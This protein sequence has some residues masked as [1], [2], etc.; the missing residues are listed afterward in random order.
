MQLP[1]YALVAYDAAELTDDEPAY[2]EVWALCADA[3]DLF[4]N[5]RP[6]AR[7]RYELLGCAVEGAL[8][9]A[10]DQARSEGSAPLGTLVLEALDKNGHRVGEWYLEDV[11]LLGDRLCA[12]DLSLRDLTVEASEPPDA[13]QADYP[14]RP[15]LSPGYL[16]LGAE[17]QP[18]GRCKDLARVADDSST[19]EEPPIRLTGCSPRG[20]LREALD[21]GEEDLGHARLLR[22][23]AFGW[24]LTSAVEGEITAWIPSARGRGLVDLTLEPW[25]D[26]PPFAAR[27][28]WD[29]WWDGRPARTNLWA[30]CSAEGRD[31][32]LTTALENRHRR[33]PH[34]RT[35]YRPPGPTYHLDG[36]H[37]TDEKGFYCAIGE[38][39]NGPGG[40]FGGNWG[41]LTDCLR[42]GFGATRPFTLIWHDAEVART[43]LGVTPRT[44]YRPATFEEFLSHLEARG[45]RVVID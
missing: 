23:D 39:V 9:T 38:A 34:R 42:G 2:D 10:L 16:L 15:A 30:P 12:R 13:Q 45:V 11:R 31:V 18:W 32:W 7:D 8:R 6:R 22:L 44:D 26:Q 4:A 24:T 27:D 43:C 33:T 28:V 5:P 29:H 25:S 36:R 37:I 19:S 3:D 41:A 40:Y 1:R 14:G 21:R 35:P 17:D 20:A